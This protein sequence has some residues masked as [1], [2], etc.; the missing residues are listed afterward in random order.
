MSPSE[1]KTRQPSSFEFVKNLSNEIS[2]IN[3]CYL[4]TISVIKIQPLYVEKN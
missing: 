2:I 3:V 1:K 4:L